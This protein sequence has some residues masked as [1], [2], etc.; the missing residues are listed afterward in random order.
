MLI[1]FHHFLR[2]GRGSLPIAA[3]VFIG[4]FSPLLADPKPAPML[5]VPMDLQQAAEIAPDL[6]ATAA[7]L[8]RSDNVWFIGKHYLWKWSPAQNALQQIKLATK[9][10]LRNLVLRGERVFVS[11]DKQLF[12]IETAPFKVI[13]F[14]SA[15]PKS[16]SLDILGEQSPIFWLKTDGIYELSPENGTLAKILDHSLNAVEE[17]HYLYVA[18]T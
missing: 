8:D 1:N 12:Q 2:W 11:D 5:E 9:M 13:S 10:V 14:T 7:V 4:S 6:P 3:T 18:P 16:Q 15:N 17:A